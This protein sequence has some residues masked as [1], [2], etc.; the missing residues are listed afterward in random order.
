MFVL[1]MNNLSLRNQELVKILT[2]E[3]YQYMSLPDSFDNILEDKVLSKMLFHSNT[4]I[5]AP[6]GKTIE[7][8]LDLFNL[9]YSNRIDLCDPVSSTVCKNI[10]YNILNEFS[11]DK[12]NSNYPK[13]MFKGNFM[14]YLLEEDLFFRNIKLKGNITFN[15]FHSI[16]NNVD[17]IN[18]FEYKLDKKHYDDYEDVANYLLRT[19]NTQIYTYLNPSPQIINRIINFLKLT[20]ILIIEEL[21]NDNM[22]ELK[23]T[24]DKLYMLLYSS[25]SE[26]ISIDNHTLSI[27]KDS[28]GANALNTSPFFST[29]IKQVDQFKAYVKDLID[30]NFYKDSIIQDILEISI[31]DD[32]NFEIIEN[33]IR[34]L[35]YCLNRESFIGN[36]FDKFVMKTKHLIP[37]ILSSDNINIHNKTKLILE[38]DNSLLFDSEQHLINLFIDI[39]KYNSE[40]GYNEKHKL[41]TKVI[42]VLEN[43]N[44]NSISQIST[45]RLNEFITIYT[46]HCIFLVNQIKEIKAKIESNQSIN[47]TSSLQLVIYLK[48]LN[49]TTKFLKNL[50]VLDNNNE[51]YLYKQIELYFSI[52]KYSL[53]SRL[54]S[55]VP[56][57]Q[58]SNV[59][60]KLLSPNCSIKL[61]EIYCRLFQNLQE[62]SKNN[63][64]V[65]ECAVNTALFD[66]NDY[67]K[68]VK[69]FGEFVYFEDAKVSDLIDSL[70]KNVQTSIENREAVI[71]YDCDIPSKFL[72]PIM[73]TEINNPYEIPDVKQ[74]LDKYTIFNHL[75]FSHTNPFTNSV[76]T[77]DELLEYNNTEEVKKRVE[78]FRS[79]FTNWKDQ[80]KM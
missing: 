47:S 80:H 14:V 3:N 79:E 15:I 74:I 32:A 19:L 66:I 65:K 68:T 4:D 52:I 16:L 26:V 56:L 54:Y 72:D 23:N 35:T 37:I 48:Y 30:L 55:E 5:M 73:F 41:R 40:T 69:Y 9:Y 62:L 11:K 76:L 1:T 53:S 75:T 36:D 21:E 2:S 34:T 51:H 13:N 18:Y 49:D 31:D 10:C 59:S 57:F 38:L 42:S 67:N 12:V 33:Q 25:V 60:K 58:Q 44:N 6:K 7:N 71:E 45:N 8:N 22:E 70:V 28:I 29:I 50:Q 17:T 61:Q 64:F 63:K 39:E 43:S 24:T 46:S 77:K 20:E 27:Y 78:D